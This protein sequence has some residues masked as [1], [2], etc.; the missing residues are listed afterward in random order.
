MPHNPLALVN[1]IAAQ[2]PVLGSTSARSSISVSGAMIG[3]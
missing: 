3:S 2:G 1:K